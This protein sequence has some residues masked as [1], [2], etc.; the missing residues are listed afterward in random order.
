MVKCTAKNISPPAPSF[1]WTVDNVT[2]DHGEVEKYGVSA[3][4]TQILHF[5]PVPQHA[6][7]TLRC[8]VR[9]PGLEREISASTEIRLTKGN[10]THDDFLLV[11]VFGGVLILIAFI[12][13]IMEFRNTHDHVV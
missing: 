8:T 11:S 1:V 13:I 5:Q 2:L 9:H 3:I 6:N 4:F 12:I 10:P 7:K